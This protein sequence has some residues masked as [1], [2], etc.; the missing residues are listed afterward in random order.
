MKKKCNLESPAVSQPL[1]G[2]GLADREA[3]RVHAN[4]TR[5]E[6]GVL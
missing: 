2:A 4:V 6:G 3:E 5:G 1:M